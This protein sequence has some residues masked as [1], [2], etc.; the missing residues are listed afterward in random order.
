LRT[1]VNGT[2]Y[3]VAQGA[4]PQRHFTSISSRFFALRAKIWKK[5]SL[6]TL[7]LQANPADDHATA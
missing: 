4:F 3:A 2:S 1:P 5:K 7:L 6:P